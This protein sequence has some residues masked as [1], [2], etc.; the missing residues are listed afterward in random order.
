MIHESDNHLDPKSNLGYFFP[1]CQTILSS[2]FT[3]EKTTTT[4]YSIYGRPICRFQLF[5]EAL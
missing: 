1:K 2:S 4:S 3:D 5:V